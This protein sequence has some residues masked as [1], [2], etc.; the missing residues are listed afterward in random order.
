MVHTSGAGTMSY[1]ARSKRLRAGS[2][3]FF[4]GLIKGEQL[5]IL[6]LSIHTDHLLMGVFSSTIINRRR[7]SGV[8]F[9]PPVFLSFRGDSDGDEGFSGGGISG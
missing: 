9:Q 8:A 5:A 3:P 4:C 2:A 7:S 1:M 6:W